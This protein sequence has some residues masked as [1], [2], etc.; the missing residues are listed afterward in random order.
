MKDIKK[1]LNEPKSKIGLVHGLLACIISFIC[2]YLTMMI[3]TLIAYGDYAHR[4]IPSI[5][6]TPVLVSIYGLY[7]LFS[8]TLNSFFKKAIFSVL[9][10]TITF[11]IVYIGF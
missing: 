1:Y 11:L 6:L 8:E 9:V 3:F 5:V 10:L 4:I 7:F 2:A